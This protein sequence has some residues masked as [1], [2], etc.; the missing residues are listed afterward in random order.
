MQ[1]RGLL[2]R[3]RKMSKSLKTIVRL[4]LLGTTLSVGV[5]MD[6]IK[7]EDETH[8]TLKSTQEFDVEFLQDNVDQVKDDE[9][10]SKKASEYALYLLSQHSKQIEKAKKASDFLSKRKPTKLGGYHKK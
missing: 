6:D 10:T 7:K 3:R 4:V 5:C 8:T 1:L 9:K 2:R